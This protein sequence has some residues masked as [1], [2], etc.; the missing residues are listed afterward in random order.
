MDKTETAKRIEEKLLKI[1]AMIL[2]YVKTSKGEK[3][4]V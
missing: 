3:K 1:E 2:R 4:D